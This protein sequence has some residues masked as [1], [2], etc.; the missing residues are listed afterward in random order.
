MSPLSHWIFLFG[1]L[2]VYLLI[3]VVVFVLYGRGDKRAGGQR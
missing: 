1:T 2:I 3:G